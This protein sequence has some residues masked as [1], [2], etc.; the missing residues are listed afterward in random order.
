MIRYVRIP[1]YIEQCA[2]D[3]DYAD[4]LPALFQTAHPFIDNVYFATLYARMKANN[5]LLNKQKGESTVSLRQQFIY[6]RAHKKTV[7]DTK[8]ST[9][10]YLFVKN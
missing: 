4:Y 5:N 9:A 6:H 7:E 10:I 3:N 1:I 2:N 8:S